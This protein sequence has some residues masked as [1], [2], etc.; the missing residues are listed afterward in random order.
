MFAG[1]VAL[2][3]I[4]GPPFGA[5]KFGVVTDEITGLKGA[6]SV[7][8]PTPEDAKAVMGTIGVSR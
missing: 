1:S 2:V 5:G 3:Q 6:G 4:T 7:P 8:I